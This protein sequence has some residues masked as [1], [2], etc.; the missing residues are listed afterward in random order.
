MLH[1]LHQL[2]KNS[3]AVF[4]IFVI[5]IILIPLLAYGQGSIPTNLGFVESSIWYGK[6]PFFADQV[7]RVYTV[8]ANSSDADFKGTVT[9]FDNDEPID[10]SEFSLTRAGGVHVV[11]V[12]WTPEAGKHVIVAKILEAEVSRTGEEPQ[13]IARED[14]QTATSI[15]FVDIDTDGDGIG[16]SE[17]SD[18]D[19]DGI[20]DE[21]DEEPLVVKLSQGEEIRS[22]VTEEAKNL[23]ATVAPI[24]TAAVSPAV[25]YLEEFRETQ[26]DRVRVLADTI[27]QELDSVDKDK[28][29][30]AVVLPGQIDTSQK[31]DTSAGEENET[32]KRAEYYALA[33]AG[34]VLDRQFVFYPLLFFISGYLIL[35]KFGTWIFRRFGSINR[36]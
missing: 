15:R 10:S 32:L 36:P 14:W 9:F 35:Y 28:E 25:V 23:Y 22:E 6:E 30:I 33:A 4:P 21:E 27:K 11:W 16:N 1:L 12:D 19:N 18:D 7:V 8:L 5:G 20:I 17:D 3:T 24:V 31:P 34:F 13:R 29:E 26:G 2:K